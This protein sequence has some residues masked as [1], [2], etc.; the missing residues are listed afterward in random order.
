MVYDLNEING[1]LRILGDERYDYLGYKDTIAVFDFNDNGINDL[2]LR[3]GYFGSIYGFYD[4]NFEQPNAFIDTG[5]EIYDLYMPYGIEA[6]FVFDKLLSLDMNGDGI[7]DLITSSM[8][9]YLWDG[10]PKIF[11][12]YGRGDK[13]DGAPARIVWRS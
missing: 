10:S 4:F 6:D 9:Y 1:D 5:E 8:S 12:I 11:V 13:L 7:D 2:I 3:R